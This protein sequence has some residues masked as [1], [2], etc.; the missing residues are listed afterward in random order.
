L[1]REQLAKKVDLHLDDLPQEIT[2]GVW[3]TGEIK[4]RPEPLGRGKQHLIREGDVW[5]PDPYKDDISLIVETPRGLVLLCGCCHAGLLNTLA[6]AEK[7]AAEKLG[8][9]DFVAIAGGTH[10][11]AADS[12]YLDKIVAVLA[13][14]PTLKRIYL[15]HCSGAHALYTLQV[16][17]GMDVA[18]PCP[19]GTE[20]DLEQST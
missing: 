8:R 9:S 19:V 1:K 4:P 5:Q 2:P 16:A 11:I 20:L 10:L 14:I 17:F 6:R 13:D 18:R 7:V 12:K 15:N 3:T